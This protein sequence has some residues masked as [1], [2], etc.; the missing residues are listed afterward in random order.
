MAPRQHIE[1]WTDGSTYPAN[2]GKGGWAAIIVGTAGE[3]Q[4]IRVLSGADNESGEEST[5]NRTELMA[6]V[7]AANA[8]KE[9]TGK[10]DL[11]TDSESYVITGLK[12][13]H[14]NSMHETHM[15]LWATLK[16]LMHFKKVHIFAHHEPSHST[17][18]MNEWAD[19]LAKDAARN[20]IC[21]DEVREGPPDH[22]IRRVQKRVERLREPVP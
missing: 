10:V 9:G 15:D 18:V 12:K 22:I 19:E 11:Y 17:S 5:N 21:I 20:G 6:V 1:I 4:K 16:T 14:F 8:L 2:P 3:K 7:E 13:L